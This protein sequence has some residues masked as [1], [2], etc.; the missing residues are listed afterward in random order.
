M[1]LVIALG[2]TGITFYLGKFIG[3]QENDVSRK[4]LFCAG[5]VFLIL[6]LAVFKYL[7]FIESNVQWLLGLVG[8]P[9]RFLREKY[10]VPVRDFVLYFSSLVLSDRQCIGERRKPERS[11]PDFTLYMLLF[12]KFLSGPLKGQGIFCHSESG[13]AFVTRT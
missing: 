12:M 8:I 13:E 10:F 5:M 2:I 11:L 3:R 7:G 1:F 4:R 6:F 9:G